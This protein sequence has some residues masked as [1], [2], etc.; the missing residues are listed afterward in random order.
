MDFLKVNCS[1]LLCLAIISLLVVVPNQAYAATQPF[2]GSGDQI[3]P[4]SG[5][6]VVSIPVKVVLVGINPG[7]VDTSYMKWN[8]NLPTTTYGQV[9][10]PQP[11]LTGVV[12]KVDYSFAYASSAFKSKLVSYL[13][14]I[15]VDKQGPN[16]WFYYPAGAPGGYYTVSNFYSLQ[17]ASY[18]ANKVEDWIYRNQQDVG[19]FPSNGW[20]LMFLNLTELPSYDFGHY[21]DFLGDY[22]SAPPNGTA[23]YYSVSY[24]DSDL[25]YKLRYRDFMTGWGGVHRFWFDDLSAG[26]SFWTD[27]EDIPLQ[28]ILKDNTLDLGTAYGRTWFTQ[29]V[30]DYVWQATWNLI[31]PFFVYDPTYSDKYTFDIHIFDNRTAQEKKK[32][33]PHSTIAVNKVKQAFQD[34][35]PYAK[36][37]ASVTFEDMSKYPQLENV[38]ESNFIYTDSFTFGV[39]G[40]PLRYGI[41][42]AR[43]VYKYLQDNIYTFEPNFRRD[44]S[45][46]TVPVFAFAFSKDTLFTFTYKWFIQRPD[47]DVKALLGVALGDVALVSMSQRQFERGNFV[48]PV[49]PNKGLGFTEVVIHESG[50][51]VGLAHPHQ[52]GSIGDFTVSAMGY[53]TYDYVFGQ[54]DKDALRRAHVDSIY[55]KVQSTMNQLAP[56]GAD[57]SPIL[58]QLKDVDGKYNQMDYEA[59]LQSVLNAESMANNMMSGLSQGGIQ[60][61]PTGS[62]ANYLILGTSLGLIM[63]FAIA[64]LLVTRKIHISR[65]KARR[66]R[67]ST[68]RRQRTS[69]S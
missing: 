65:P 66:P 33:A 44:R 28:I 61:G 5:S 34:L 48:S 67:R 60:Q 27:Y 43:P 17:Y 29:Y 12:Y 14:G 42:D 63:G 52:F 16:P 3:S 57:V 1:N 62:N 10:N 7:L 49:Q 6:R 19:G 64:W 4:G 55:L 30:A 51:M 41:V 21:S 9:L 13:Q 26:P 20:T 35:M 15:E 8:F 32:I 39:N 58:N 53:Y 69:R 11:Y 54:S 25:G 18:D 68:R 59:A 40:Q 47:S 45:E 46:F 36:I 38:I 31:M 23:H 24:R 37:D 50:H 56:R 22:R 2:G